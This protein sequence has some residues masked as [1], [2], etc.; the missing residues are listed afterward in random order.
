MIVFNGTKFPQ[1]TGVL[2]WSEDFGVREVFE[3]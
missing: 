1:K 3:K 2:G